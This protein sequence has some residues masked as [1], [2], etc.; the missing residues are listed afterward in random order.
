MSLSFIILVLV[1]ANET[2]HW[3]NFNCVLLLLLSLRAH[4]VFALGGS[5][6][7]NICT[8]LIADAPFQLFVCPI[9]LYD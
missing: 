5:F 3:Y 9:T 6:D 8:C 7:K 4:T 1:S 2:C